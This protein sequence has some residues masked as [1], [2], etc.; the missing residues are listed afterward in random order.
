MALKSLRTDTLNRVSDINGLVHIETQT[1]SS[2]AAI[3][4]NN[5]FTSAF[6]NY[7][8][9]G[10]ATLSSAALRLRLRLA[11]SDIT[12]SNYN[13]HN[14]QSLTNAATYAAATS[15][16]QSFYTLTALSAG[17]ISNFHLKVQ[18]PNNTLRTGFL[19][20]SMTTQSASL[21]GGMNYG[22]EDNILARDGFSIITSSGNFSGTISVYGY[23]E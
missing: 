9:I 13:F 1:D 12:T 2:V 15:P 14:Q 18:D 21:A 8:I 5:V 4:F 23:K 7:L 22:S 19:G 16:G 6:R 17:L 20:Q 10:N 11:G 3:N